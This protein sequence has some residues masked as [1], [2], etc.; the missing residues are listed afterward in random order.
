M[1]K[2]KHSTAERRKLEMNR[3]K[4]ETGK[5]QSKEIKKMKKKEIRRMTIR[6]TIHNLNFPLHLWS[7]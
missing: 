1:T 5:E 4:E 2:G 7:L 6:T 3:G